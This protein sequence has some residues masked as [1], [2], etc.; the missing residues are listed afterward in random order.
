MSTLDVYVVEIEASPIIVEVH[1][2][3]SPGLPG[4]GSDVSTTMTYNPD[5]T[6]ATLTSSVGT[7]AFNYSGGKL[8]SITGTGGYK[9]KT[10]TYTGDKVT[11]I[12]VT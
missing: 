9:S 6:L 4:A 10:L 7:K 5:G 11:S 2:L 12:T 8:T 3:G 1:Q